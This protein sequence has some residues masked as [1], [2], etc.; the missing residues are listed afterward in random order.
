MALVVSRCSRLQAMSLG[1]T[2]Q[3]SQDG[4]VTGCH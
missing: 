2:Q 1:K 3:I 4:V